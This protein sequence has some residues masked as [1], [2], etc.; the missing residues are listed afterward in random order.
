MWKEFLLKW[1][2]GTTVTHQPN[3]CAYSWFCFTAQTP[4]KCNNLSYQYNFIMVIYIYFNSS[5]ASSDIM[6]KG[7]LRTVTQWILM[8]C[9][10][11]NVFLCSFLSYG[12]SKTEVVP[13]SN[14]S[15]LRWIISSSG[16]QMTWIFERVCNSID[17]LKI[18]WYL[19]LSTIPSNLIQLMKSS[20]KA[21][22]GISAEGNWTSCRSLDKLAENLHKHKQ[23]QSLMRLPPCFSMALWAP[24]I[25][26]DIFP[27]HFVNLTRKKTGL[28]YHL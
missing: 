3:V 22:L 27:L 23:S 13:Q 25:Y 28:K 19:E 20:H 15:I 14:F 26:T 17:W 2:L 7:K 8:L 10:R 9:L 21:C 4:F 18:D 24:Q 5:E 16:S 12:W 1:S 6:A 11:F